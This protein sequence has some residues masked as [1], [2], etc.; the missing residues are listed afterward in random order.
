MANGI[1]IW[2][3]ASAID[4]KPVVVVARC[5]LHRMRDI[6]LCFLQRFCIAAECPERV[7]KVTRKR[8]DRGN[9]FDP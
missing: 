9:Q 3:G 2:E 1:I 6:A 4:G 7:F 8:V 5:N